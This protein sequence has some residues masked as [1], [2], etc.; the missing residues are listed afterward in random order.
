MARSAIVTL[1][2]WQALGGRLRYV[3][4]DIVIRAP[5]DD[6]FHLAQ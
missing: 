3:M 1:N 5:H 6:A 4:A 2:Q